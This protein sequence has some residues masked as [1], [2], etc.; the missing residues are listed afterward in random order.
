MLRLGLDLGSSYTKGAIVDGEL[1]L[2]DR[3]AVR[4][5]YDFHA[6]ATEIIKTF[7]L[8]YQIESPVF[9]CGYGREQVGVPFVPNSE[10]TALA[11]AVY[12]LHGR[13][14][15]ILDIGGQD[16]K[17]IRIADDGLIEKFKVNRKCAAGTGAFLEEIAFRLGV[18]PEKFDE[19]A[20]QANE[21]I[22]INS[23]CTVFAVSELI[24][25]IKK[26][27]S[28]PN[29]V[30]GVY[31]CV[32]TRALE[33][34]PPDYP[35]ILTGGL[36]ARHPRIIKLFKEIYPDVESPEMAQFMAAHGSVL[37]NWKQK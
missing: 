36:A 33:L 4:T 30:M 16:T 7:S 8:K 19:L 32:V 24:G 25:L 29:I 34:A 11:K 12:R 28:L 23:F 35:I 26:G 20:G 17:F 6:A 2:I 27:I 31:R 22:E 1:N 9:S 5:G 15:V 3:L 10:I 13:K 37:L 14:A 21:K 18:A